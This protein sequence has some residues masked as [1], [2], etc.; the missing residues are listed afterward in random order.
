MKSNQQRKA[1][2]LAR[3]KQA[4]DASK[5]SDLTLA[6]NPVPQAISAEKLLDY[7]REQA[8]QALCTVQ[9]IE[10]VHAAPKV[11]ADYLT[12]HEQPAL[13]ALANTSAFAQ[14]DWHGANM[15]ISHLLRDQQTRAVMVEADYAIAETGTLIL[16][17]SPQ[18]PTTLNFLCD[19]LIVLVRIENIVA[20]YES[21]WDSLKEHAKKNATEFDLPRVTNWVTGPSKTADIEQTIQLGAHSAQRVLILL[22]QSN[23]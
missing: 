7:F 11:I 1:A 14:L 13:L 16:T 21:A 20:Y 18:Q 6:S 2:I 4:Q 17:S 8:T 10:T 9:D 12:Q 19:T 22:L 15:E 5:S 23:S 3:I